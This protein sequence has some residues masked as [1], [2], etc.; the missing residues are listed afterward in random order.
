MRCLHNFFVGPALI[1]GGF[2]L[3]KFPL[4]IQLVGVWLNGPT[5]VVIKIQVADGAGNL[6]YEAH[7]SASSTNISGMGFVERTVMF[8]VI[9]GFNE[10]APLPPEFVIDPSWTVTITGV[11][12]STGISMLIRGDNLS[13]ALFQEIRNSAGR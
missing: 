8:D 1:T 5:G 6:V 12:T 11:G 4:P 13:E 2:V 10:I 7:G 9:N 3:P